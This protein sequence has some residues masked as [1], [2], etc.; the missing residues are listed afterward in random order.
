MRAALRPRASLRAAL[1]EWPRWRSQLER[2]PPTRQPSAAAAKGIHATEPTA[3][4]LKP[5]ASS[6]YFG[7]PEHVKI[8]RRVGKKFGADHAPRFAEAEEFAHRHRSGR[9]R[10]GFFGARRKIGFCPPHRPQQPEGAGDEKHPAPRRDAEPVDVEDDRGDERRRN[11]AP[12]ARAGV[13]DSHRRGA[14]FDRKP[15]GD[16][17]RGRGKSTA[18]TDAKEEPAGG[19][20]DHATGESVARAS[21]GPKHHDDEKAA[22]RAE[23]VHETAAA[24]IHQAVGEEEGRIEKGLNR[25][26]NRDLALNLTDGDRQRLAVQIADGDGGADEKGDV[27]A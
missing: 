27:P 9:S 23:D 22:F 21:E 5:R 7:E 20:R 16:D 11:H 19:E 3:L 4:M 12:D 15:F 25:I 18:F 26:R 24:D 10:V 17:S 1:T 2:P 13:D 6:R 8:P 14:V